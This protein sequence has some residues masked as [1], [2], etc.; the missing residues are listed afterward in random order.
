MT[1]DQSAPGSARSS[2][3]LATPERVL[4]LLDLRQ[5]RERQA[6]RARGRA[7]WRERC[8]ALFGGMALAGTTAFLLP[9]ALRTLADLA[10]RLPL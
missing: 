6:N 3:P 7:K 9:F 1:Y 4:H 2:I 10:E 5:E 8:A